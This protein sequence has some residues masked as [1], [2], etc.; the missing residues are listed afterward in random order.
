MNLQAYLRL[1]RPINC[2]MIGLAVL[3]GETVASSNLLFDLNSFFGF[4][5]GFF[6]TAYSMVINDILDVEV[7]KANKS[8]RP[9]ATGEIKQKDAW[10]YSFFLLAAGLVFSLFTGLSTFLIAAIF[11]GL[12]AAY[13]YKLKERGLIGNLSVAISMTVPFIYGGMLV[14]RPFDPLL[15]FMALTAFFAGVGREVIKGITD[16]EGDALRRV[17][18]IARVKGPRAASIVGA[19]LFLL[20]VITS[21]LPTLLVK[22]TF[23]YRLLIDITDILFIFLALYIVADSGRAKFVKNMALLGM[24]IGLIGFILQGTSI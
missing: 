11:A 24:L 19:S 22:V 2:F 12:S 7:D 8:N 1:I 16:I 10:I 13:N 14:S 4:L 23:G 17:K 3:V 9:L 20:A 18:S 5:T 21:Q 15:D 6:I